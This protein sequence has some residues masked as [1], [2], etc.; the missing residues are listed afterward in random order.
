MRLAP[1]FSQVLKHCCKHDHD[2]SIMGNVSANLQEKK[3]MLI[4][5][6]SS[7]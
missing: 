1:A 4:Q 2:G 3:M 5:S 6:T 7:P